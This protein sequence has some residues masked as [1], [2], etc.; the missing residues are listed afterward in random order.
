MKKVSMFNNTDTMNKYKIFIELKDMKPCTIEGKIY[1]LVPLFKFLSFKKAEEITKQDIENYFI[2]M[3]R[4]NKRKSTQLKDFMS[5][6]AF[7]N[8]L[9]PNNNCFENIKMKQE[10]LFGNAG[11]KPF[12]SIFSSRPFS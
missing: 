11:L 7:F 3:K 6:R 5:I 1:T 2:H 12:S 10:K 9:I 8:W 4:S